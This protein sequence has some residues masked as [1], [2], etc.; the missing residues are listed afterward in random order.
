[1]TLLEKRRPAGPSAAAPRAR[2]AAPQG[3]R[4][5]VPVHAREELIVDGVKKSFKKRMVVRGISINLRRGE[6]VGLLG[7]NGA[8]K[9][10]VFYMITGLIK[11]DRGRIELDGYEVTALPMYQRAR[12]GIGYLP[13]EASIFRGLNVEENIRA[14]LEV[15]EPDKRRREADLNALLEEFNIARLRKTPTI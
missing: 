1:M 3:R 2:R 5:A 4:A 12:L 14:V 8:G 7:P 13:Q 9:T 6:S 11:A 15:V 10:T